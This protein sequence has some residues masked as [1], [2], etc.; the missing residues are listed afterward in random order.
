MIGHICLSFGMSTCF[1][2]LLINVEY[3]YRAGKEAEA[4]QPATAM[5]GNLDESILSRDTELD[6]SLASKET[7]LLDSSMNNGDV[8]AGMEVRYGKLK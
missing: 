8:E 6:T 1:Y 4:S 3:F 2:S 5:N 7:A